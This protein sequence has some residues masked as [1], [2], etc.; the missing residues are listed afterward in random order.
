MIATV[1]LDKTDKNNHFSSLG[2]KQ[3]H[4]AIRKALMFENW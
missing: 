1:K 4:I 2:I 3:I